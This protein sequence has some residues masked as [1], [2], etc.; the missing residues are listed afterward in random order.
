MFLIYY[1]IKFLLKKLSSSKLLVL[2]FLSYILLGTILVSFPFSK[3]VDV[4]FIDNLFNITSAVSTTGLVTTSISDSYTIF[5]QIIIMLFFQLGGICY[6]SLST[7]ILLFRGKQ[8]SDTR[9]NIL[10][11]EYS[12]P[13]DFRIQDFVYKL[14]LFTI[15]IETIGTLIL[16]FEFKAAGVENSFYSAI[17]HTISAFATA[18]FS[19]NN[20]SLE[21][22]KFNTIVN[23]TI[24]ILCYLGALGFIVIMDLYNSIRIR[25]YKISFTTKVIVGATF[26]IL[27]IETP[28]FYFFEPSISSYSSGNKLLVSFF[29]IMTAS[30]T[31]GFNSLN[32]GVLSHSSLVL[33]LFCMIIGASPSGTGGG[34]KT[35]AFIAL[36][37]STFSILK[38]ET[39]ISFFGNRIPLSRLFSAVSSATIYLLTLLVGTFLLS[40]T[41][42]FTFMEIVF[43]IT[44]ALGT[45]GLSMGITGNLS[46]FAKYILV[47]IMFIGRVG[48]LSIGFAL[49]SKERE[50]HDT[51]KDADL[52][53]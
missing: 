7:F 3:K 14:V 38:G 1:K 6:M 35:T 25:E 11:S 51:I 46:T 42:N 31:A 30:T 53:V 39:Y 33:I 5:G 4:S 17:F 2:G 23:V 49:L 18:G 32:I 21:D 8:I 45:V 20:N 34:I 40:I 9:K 36:L 28:L 48:P 13:K 10:T 50:E 47:I 29:Q 12:I 43:E 22:F 16:Y 52:A 44:S 37:A 15:F 26:I 24:S 19:L 27:F 41:E